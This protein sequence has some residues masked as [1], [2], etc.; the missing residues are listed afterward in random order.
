MSWTGA[1]RLTLHDLTVR[2]W[3]PATAPD[4][5]EPPQAEAQAGRSQ[6]KIVGGDRG[7]DTIVYLLFRGE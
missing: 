6:E 3:L 4:S 7:V 1:C 2:R 5:T